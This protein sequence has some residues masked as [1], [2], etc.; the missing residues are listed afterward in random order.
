MLK[1]KNITKENKNTTSIKIES[2][3]FK[4]TNHEQKEDLE[5]KEV[6]NEKKL[7]NILFIKSDDNG[8]FYEFEKLNGEKHKFYFEM[9]ENNIPKLSKIEDFA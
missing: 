4:S 9:N 5:L 3:T 2:N 8:K 1:E 7:S 6:K